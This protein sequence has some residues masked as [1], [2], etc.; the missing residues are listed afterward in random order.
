MSIERTD[1]TPNPNT[2]TKALAGAWRAVYSEAD[3]RMSPVEDFAGLTHRFEENAF[4]V[5][6]GVGRHAGTFSLDTSKSPIEV[7]YIY[8]ES[9]GPFLGAPRR[10]LI[11]LEGDT[12]K[13]CMGPIGHDSPT[14]FNTKPGSQTVLT[15]F[16]RLDSHDSLI[17]NAAALNRLTISQW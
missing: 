16:Q 17:V 15:V 5:D 6:G 4:S 9:D 11:Q 1:C 12:L 3:G 8:K 13:L 14:D 2:F 7:I 10:G